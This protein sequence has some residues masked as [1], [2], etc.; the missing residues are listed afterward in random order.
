MTHSAVTRDSC[1]DRELFDD[2]SACGGAG[3]VPAHA[4]RNQEDRWRKQR[5]LIDRANKAAIGCGPHPIVIMPESGLPHQ[6]SRHGTPRILPPAIS[7]P[8]LQSTE[9]NTA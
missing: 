3:L 9:P 8:R 7:H 2:D 5:V 4:V 6:G 1:G